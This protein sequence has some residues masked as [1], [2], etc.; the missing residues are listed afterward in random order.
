MRRAAII[1]T[2]LYLTL[3]LVAGILLCDGT[4]HPGRRPLT[5]QDEAE[6]QSLAQ[7]QNAS[8]HDL[9]ITARD[10][11]QLSAWLLTPAEPN[12][13]A[14]IALHGL[15]DNRTGMFGYAQ[16]L[17]AHH[18]TVLLPDARA[19]GSSGGTIATYGLLERNDIRQWFDWLTQNEH[20]SCID[21]F[22]ESMGA[23][24]LLQSLAVE[25]NF[26]AVAAESSFSNFREIGYDRAGQFFHTGPWLGRTLL[27]PAL[28]FAFWYGQEKYGLDL[29]QVSP[30]TAVAATKTPV[31]LIHGKDDSNI[32]VRHSERIA[33]LNPKVVLWEVPQADHCGA[34]STAPEE[35]KFKLL[36]WYAPNK[37]EIKNLQSKNQ[38]PKP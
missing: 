13:I 22:G 11:V 15:G 25:P 12:H 33:A 3:S 20:P 34:I 30:E 14:V 35:F 37:S 36:R 5:D 23:A 10:N 31:L 24:Q 7:S 26:C 28:A 6:A 16:L 29:T 32:P 8:L 18:F 19:H 4:L 27:S 1:L 21:G 38:P 17:L 2:L 9:S